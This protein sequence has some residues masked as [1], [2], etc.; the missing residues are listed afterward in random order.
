MSGVCDVWETEDMHTG[1]WRRKLFQRTRLEDLGLDGKI[2]LKWIFKKWWV[3]GGAWTKCI[4]FR[5]GT[6][7][8]H[9]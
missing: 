5:I 6:A 2:T 9:L 7:G 8:G 1:F 3:G 4:L